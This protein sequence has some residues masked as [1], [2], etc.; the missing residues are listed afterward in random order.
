LWDKLGKVLPEDCRWV[1][2][3]T[4][5]LAHPKTGIIFAF[6]GGTLPYALRLPEPELGE[7]MR[8]S[9]KRVHEYSSGST[10]NLDDIGE[11]WVF[12]GWF[13]DEERWCLAA[14]QFA[15]A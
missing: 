8:A 2:Y 14:Y 5:V 4:P 1:V 10:L 12:G 9:D 6:A 13:A 7:A 15:G 11:E 3:G